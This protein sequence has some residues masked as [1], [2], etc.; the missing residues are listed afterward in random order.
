MAT[1]PQQVGLKIDSVIDKLNADWDLGLPRRHGAEANP[2][3]EADKLAQ[4]CFQWIRYFCWKTDTLDTLLSEFEVRARQTHS[5]WIFKPSQERGTLPILP[6]TKSFVA[7]E[8]ESQR[9][10]G[11]VRLS[12]DQRLELLKLLNQVMKDD[13]ELA[14]LSES[15][16]T[17]KASISAASFVTA[18]STPRKKTVHR[19]KE[20][21][22]TASHHVL[23]VSESIRAEADEPELKDPMTKSSKRTLGSPN[24]VSPIYFEFVFQSAHLYLQRQKRQQTLSQFLHPKP[25][26]PPDLTSA[27]YQQITPPQ[28]PNPP[29]FETAPSPALS[30]VFSS[31]GEDNDGVLSNATSMLSTQADQSQ[32]LFP[33]QECNDIFEDEDFNR[34]F[35][36]ACV[37]PSKFD[38]TDLLQNNPFKRQAMLP[39]EL[40]FWYC[41]EVHRFAPLL[42]LLPIELEQE[43]KQRFKRTK[44]SSEELWGLLRLMCSEKGIKTMPPR[45]DLPDWAMAENKYEHEGSNK[46]VYFTA[47][48][49]WEEDPSRGLLQFRLNET[50][51][52]HSCRFHRKLGA[53]RFI[54]ITAPVFSTYPDKVRRLNRD[55]TPLHEKITDFLASNSH[56]IAGRYWRVCYVED[57]TPK[58][59][60]K[61]KQPRRVKITLFAESGYGIIP[62][63]I[64]LSDLD[65]KLDRSYPKL[66]V[67]DLLQWHMPIDTNLGSTDLKLFSRMSLGFS[68]TAPTIELLQ[69][70]FLYRHDPPNGPIMDDGC[71]LLSYPLAKAIWASYGGEGE[72]PSAVQGRVSG[73]KGLWIVDYQGRCRDVSERDYWIEVSDSQLKIKPHPRDRAEA[74]ATQRTFEVLKFWGDCREGQLNTQLVTILKD[75]SVPRTLLREALEADLRSFSDSLS[76]ALADPVAL[77]LWMQERGYSSR[78]GAVKLLA[79]FPSSPKDQMKLLLESGFHP[80]DCEK[81]Q[82]NAACILGDH[83]SDYLDKMKIKLPHSTVVFCAPDPCD[84]LAEDEVFLGFS[85]PITHPISGISESA[86]DNTAVLLARNPAYLAS[87]MQLRRAVYK[88]ELRHYKNVILFSTKGQTS[89]A[90]LL[91]GGDYDGDTVTCI[92][93][94]RF[95]EHFRNVDMPR[96]PTQRDCGMVDQSRPLSDI[97]RLGRS[98]AEGMDDFLRGCVAFNARSNLLGACSTEHERLVYSLSQQHGDDKLSTPGAVTLAALAGYL[99]DSS[100]QGWSLTDG[101]WYALRRQASGPQQ[102]PVPG[103][104]GDDA[105]RRNSGAYFN[106]IDFL[107]FDVAKAL[108]DQVLSD[109]AH[110]RQ[111]VGTYDRSLTQYW[112]N[113]EAKMQTEEEQMMRR[114]SLRSDPQTPAD[115]HSPIRADILKGKSG[116]DSQISEVQRLWEELK[117]R[118]GLG[119]PSADFSDREKFN[120]AVREVYERYKAIEPVHVDHY[121]RQQYEEERE[122]NH[123]FPYWSLLKASRLYAKVRNAGQPLSAWAWYVAGRELCFLKT[124]QS[125]DVKVMRGSMHELLRVDTKYTKRLVES[126]VHEE[127]LP[128]EADDLGDLTDDDDETV[129]LE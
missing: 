50:H 56:Q 66:A 106:V 33:T 88:H 15:Y 85:K 17:E 8:V 40:P 52:E 116:L 67:E 61:K 122:R 94:P 73:A 83:M 13:R 29:S 82:A 75:R 125:A 100:K 9:K 18:P 71:A 54:V 14:R 95:I 57:E 121:L 5:K 24:G 105:P 35:S 3:D 86:L 70:E 36:E 96:M 119:S 26:P 64:K 79:S 102:L 117:A 44:T 16:S 68:K 128:E 47:T 49:D 65:P 11:L 89:T 10:N 59:R 62:Q 113:E 55:K 77:R 104:K 107:K 81:L 124:L 87:D 109:F 31:A 129:A 51:L 46:V 120:S 39:P 25:V 60:A 69:N 80:R 118:D 34:S 1:T 93:D 22:S 41:W 72:V 108:S 90:S 4:K 103:Y 63:P 53:D 84:V 123:P 6:V 78:S 43:L 98:A 20:Q 27:T 7:R 112:K 42:Q 28:P 45:S 110:R 97:F 38:P 74:D 23:K 30:A 58:S 91:S 21:F 127:V 114:R 101:A 76:N 2:A 115:Q 99:V 19:K 37:P 32:D 12:E 126:G 92:W 48:L 111:E